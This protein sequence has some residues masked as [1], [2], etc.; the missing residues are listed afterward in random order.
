MSVMFAKRLIHIVFRPAEEWRMINGEGTT[1]RHLFL[2]YIIPLTALWPILAVVATIT[3]VFQPTVGRSPMIGFHV[4]VMPGGEDVFADSLI[5]I[6]LAYGTALVLPFAMALVIYLL[7]PAFLGQKDLIRAL[8]LV[9]YAGTPVWCALCVVAVSDWGIGPWQLNTIGSV[10][11]L[12]L[13]SGY[14]IYLLRLGLPLLMKVPKAKVSFLMAYAMIFFLVLAWLLNPLKAWDWRGVISLVETWY[15]YN[16]D[17]TVVLAIAALV[18]VAII[19]A[20]HHQGGRKS[21]R[22]L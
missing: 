18:A 15:V 7:A 3:W 20:R 11:L 5:A 12:T 14:A 13:A 22:V 10:V 17:V 8:Q 2:C 1:I 6:M 16:G 21:E 19:F 9:V 4:N